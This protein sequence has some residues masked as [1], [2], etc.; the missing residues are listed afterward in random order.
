MIHLSFE[1]LFAASLVIAALVLTQERARAGNLAR[2]RAW[3]EIDGNVAVPP[4]VAGA[5]ARHEAWDG[6][7]RRLGIRATVGQIALALLGVLLAGM[8]AAFFIGVAPAAALAVALL[9]LAYAAAN[10]L[11][12]RR[13]N[14]LGGQM[15]G[16][17]DRV[18]QLLSAGNSLPTAFVRAVQGSQPAL[19]DFFAP[20]VR[21]LHNGAGFADSIAQ[22]AAEWD[23]YELDLFSAAVTANTRFGGSLGHSLSNLVAY[24]RRRAAIERELRSSTSQIRASA[25]VLGLL[26][27]LVAAAIVT[28]NRD[29]AS[30]FLVHAAGRLMLIYCGVSQ[31]TGAILMRMIVRTKF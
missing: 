30:W 20:T 22:C 23:L 19:A 21:R 13:L 4:S 5:V 8:A 1:L 15:P 16:F 29:Y 11:A 24:L 27:S 6:M 26:P 3:L 2:L 9:L 17:F 7:R 14:R 12:A 10:I 31:L 25:W 18:R 28:Q